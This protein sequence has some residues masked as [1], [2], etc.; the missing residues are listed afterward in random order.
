MP[1]GS[2]IRLSTRL[3]LV[4]L[5]L[6]LSGNQ[7][8]RAT[9]P[10]VDPSDEAVVARID[11]RIRQ[12]WTANNLRPSPQATD[13]EWCRRVYLDL[14]GR[15]PT[16]KELDQFLSNKSRTR[17]KE[18]VDQLLG[19]EY[20]DT[21]VEHWT[22]IW[23]NIL[24]GRTGGQDRRTL[25]S[26]EGMS[27]FVRNSLAANKPYDVFTSELLTATGASQPYNDTPEDPYN[28]AVNFLIEKMD[29]GGIQ[30]TAKTAEIFLG[31]AVQ[32]TQ[33]HNHPFNEYRQNQFWELNAF[34]R[35]A[36]T[37]R[38]QDPENE[39]RRLGYLVNRDYAGEGRML[40]RDGRSEIFLEERNGQLVD[41][42]AQQ[43]SESPIYYE[44][45]NGQVEVAYPVFIDGTALEDVLADRESEF[46]NSGYLEHVDRR[47]ELARLV[48]ESREFDQAI[49]NRLWAHFLGYGF[50]K[51]IHDMGPHNQPSHP[52]LLD[53]LGEAFRASGFNLQSLQRWIVLSEPYSLSSRISKKNRQDDPALGVAPQF[54]RFYVRQM[55]AEQLYES[56]LTATQADETYAGERRDQMRARWLQQ[57]S[58]AFGTDDGG[59]TSTF[60]GSIP[61]TLMMMN[62]DLVRRACSTDSGSF[63]DQVA[64]NWEMS[65][66]EKIQYLYRAALARMP[67]KEETKVC[68]ALLASRQ[69]DVVGTLQ[70]IWWA[71]LNSNEFILIH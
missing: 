32:C 62:G 52:E 49:V 53:E 63:L 41:R 16:V 61:Q 24:I 2:R 7:Q 31:T 12:G 58:T 10:Q 69:G 6:H 43:V 45:R 36:R 67:S 56:L 21:F 57:F 18:L 42:D 47:Q 20:Q 66:R 59:E 60:N 35:Q 38:E 30:A 65:N 1:V 34:F 8:L 54:S 28:G 13:A 48:V 19:S 51:P 3:A 27:D 17:R 23:T 68:N 44:L 70:D 4:V 14:I 50:T 26:R 11:E 39:N 46:G 5:M 64:N 37:E 9:E 25:T 29:E 71:V 22:A 40:Y 55:Q 33:C 15:V